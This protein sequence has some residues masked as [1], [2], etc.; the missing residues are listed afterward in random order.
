MKDRIRV[1][2]R[3]TRLRAMLRGGQT[4]EEAI[5]ATQLALAETELKAAEERLAKA[6]IERSQAEDMRAHVR[7]A[8][9]DGE[10]IE[11]LQWTPTGGQS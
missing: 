7:K 8:I 5:A 1:Q 10:R 6:Q 2:E 11:R 9:A 4:L 3:I